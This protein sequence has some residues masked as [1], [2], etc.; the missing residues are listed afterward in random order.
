MGAIPSGPTGGLS[1]QNL[2]HLRFKI[3]AW[4][5]RTND[6]G[7]N[8]GGRPKGLPY[9][10]PK[11]SRFIVFIVGEGLKVNRPKAERSHPG[12]CPSRGPVWD[13]PLRKD[14]YVSTSAVGAGAL[15]RPLWRG[16]PFVGR[17][18]PGCAAFPSSIWRAGQ[19]P[20][21]TKGRGASA[22]TVGAAHLGR[23][24]ATGFYSRSSDRPTR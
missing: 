20:A 4:L 21:P 23:P 14:R 10:K 12:V 24:P 17:G 19:C 16:T 13:R 9:A 15:T 1:L 18:L 11:P 5:C 2:E 22:Y 3:C 6:T 7:V 8:P